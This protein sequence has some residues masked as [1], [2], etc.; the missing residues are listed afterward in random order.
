MN[1][2]FIETLQLDRGRSKRYMKQLRRRTKINY[3]SRKTN[4]HKAIFALLH[5]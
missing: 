3:L 5:R 4:K 1:S 2:K